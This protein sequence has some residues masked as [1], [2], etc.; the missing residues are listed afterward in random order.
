MYVRTRLNI[1][2]VDTAVG[3]PWGEHPDE[4]VS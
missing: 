4:M 1:L 2:A 3:V